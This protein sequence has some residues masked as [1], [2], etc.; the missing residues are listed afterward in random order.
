[1]T[2]RK[3]DDCTGHFNNI[4][5]DSDFEY[6]HFCVLVCKNLEQSREWIMCAINDSNNSKEINTSDIA[7][8]LIW[9]EKVSEHHLFLFEEFRHET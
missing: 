2:D 7:H 8:V 5:L 9:I 4:C 3:H 6:V 1:M